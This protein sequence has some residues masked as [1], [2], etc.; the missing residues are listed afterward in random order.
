M[1]VGS[2]CQLRCLE[3]DDFLSVADRTVEFVAGFAAKR[4]QCKA[5]C[6]CSVLFWSQACHEPERVL[7][8]LRKALRHA[9]GAIQNDPLDIILFV[10][11]LDR[12]I[13]LFEDGNDAI[14]PS[15]LTGLLSLYL[16]H[17]RYIEGH[18][19]AEARRALLCTAAHLQAKVPQPKLEKLQ[20]DLCDAFIFADAA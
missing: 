14:T 5:M 2:L 1:I 20:K 11:V 17:I 6:L 19:P 9:D 18:A 8:C 12:A 4:D 10:E 16:H 7:M 13:H 3:V 15:F